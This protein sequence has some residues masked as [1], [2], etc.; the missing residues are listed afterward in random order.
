[1]TTESE[2]IKAELNSLEEKQK[3][4]RARLENLEKSSI[5]DNSISDVD[6]TIPYSNNSNTNFKLTKNK[7][8]II[9]IITILIAIVGITF[10]LNKNDEEETG[11]EI[12]LEFLAFSNWSYVLDKLGK[13]DEETYMDSLYSYKYENII[14]YGLKGMVNILFDNSDD[15]IY[16]CIFYSEKSDN[17]DKIL[18]EIVNQYD[19]TYGN[20]T[21]SESGSYVWYFNQNKEIYIY[22][23]A[24]EIRITVNN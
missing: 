2:S 17:K 15:S 18:R 12:D 23:G 24:N 8:I 5:S 19:K 7:I 1:M 6:E 22:N 11:K 21:I 13:P 14:C 10:F 16:S 3:E 4:L 20:H 9:C